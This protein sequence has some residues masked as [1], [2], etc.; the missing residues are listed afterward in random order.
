MI[1][2]TMEEFKTYVGKSTGTSPWIKLANK[3]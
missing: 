2:Y 1:N 3:E